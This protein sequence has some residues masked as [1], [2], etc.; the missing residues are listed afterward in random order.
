MIQTISSVFGLSISHISPDTS[1][2][3]GASRPQNAQ[4]SNAKIESLGI[5]KHTLF[6]EGIQSVLDPWI[7]TN[8]SG[9]L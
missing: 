9:G 3:P 1:P 4:L 2:S 5:G 6:R 8:K 7:K